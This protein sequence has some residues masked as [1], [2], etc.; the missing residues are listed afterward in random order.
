MITFGY[1]SKFSSILRACAAIA[2]GAVMIISTNATETVVR[3]IA[4]FLFAA[5]LVSLLYGYTNRKSG[6]MSLLSVNAVVDIAL[7]LVLFLFPHGVAHLITILIGIALL[8]FGL[9]QV[10]VLSGTLSLVGSGLYSV[11]LSGLAVLAGVILVFNPFSQTIMS[12][13][14]G[15]ALILYG[16]SELISTVRVNKAEKAYEIKYGSVE[17]EESSSLKD[18]STSGISDAKEVEYEKIDDPAGDS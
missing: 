3:V 2:I 6:A 11:I 8:L 15:A 17:R 5:G 10:V 18:F 4:A 12:I 7:G 16:V 13:I 14:A 1:K 9:L